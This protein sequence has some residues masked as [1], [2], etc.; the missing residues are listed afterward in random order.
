MT[1]WTLAGAC[2]ARH[3]CPAALVRLPVGIVGVANVDEPGAGIHPVAHRLEIVRVVLASGTS[4]ICEPV[5]RASCAIVSK[6]GRAVSIVLP[7]PANASEGHL[8]DFGRS[9]TQHDAVERHAMKSAIF[10]RSDAAAAS[11]YRADCD[12]ASR[13]AASAFGDGPCALSLR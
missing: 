8:Q 2:E 7:R 4:T 13:I 5:R 12:A 1:T 6:V 9:A 11:G 3:R 10:R